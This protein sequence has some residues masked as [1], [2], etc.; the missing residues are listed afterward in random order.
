MIQPNTPTDQTLWVGVD[1]GK[2][3]L[4]VYRAKDR[5]SLTIPNERP[6]IKRFLRQNPGAVLVLEATGGYEAEL[7]EAGLAKGHTVYRVNARRVR[8]FME[9]KGIYAKTDEIDAKALAAYAEANAKDLR[10]FEPPSPEAKKLRQLTRRRDELVALRTQEKNRLQ[11]PD[12]HDLRQ[13]IRAVLTCADKQIDLIEKQMQGLL[14]S[15]PLLKEKVAV[16]KAVKGVGLVTAVNLL[17]SM[18]ELGQLN[19]KQIASLAG[20]AP[21]PHNSGKKKGHRRTKRGGRAEV[22][23]IIYMAALVASRRNPQLAKAY[24]TLIQNG[25]KPLVA[26][27]AIARRLLVILNAKIRDSFFPIA[28]Q[29]S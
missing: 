24:N 1:V 23:R 3:A 18:P 16:L 12:N 20:L 28:Y 7:I 26:L 15:S 21:H 25:K 19:G 13:S 27:I 4:A 6:A 17:A 10:P 9:S 29:E 8:A 11:A 2:E 22:R 14:E 5:S